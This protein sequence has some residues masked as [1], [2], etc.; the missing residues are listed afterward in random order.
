MTVTG[1]GRPDLLDHRLR[2]VVEAD[3]FEVHGRRQQ[4]TRDCRRDNAFVTHG[5]RVVRFSWEQVMF[6]PGYVTEVLTLMAQP[7][8]PAAA[9]SRTYAA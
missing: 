2:L 4:L 8:R 6:E 3:S 1:D 5:W 7:P 9:R